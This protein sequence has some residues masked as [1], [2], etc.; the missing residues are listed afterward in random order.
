[1]FIHRKKS[2]VVQN[3]K[4]FLNFANFNQIFIQN[5]SKLVTPLKQFTW[6]N[7]QIECEN[8]SNIWDSKEY[9]YNYRYSKVYLFLETILSR[10]V[11]SWFCPWNHTF[12]IIPS[13][14]QFQVQYD[15]N[16]IPKINYE[17]TT[18]NFEPLSTPSKSGVIFLNYINVQSRYTL[19]TWFSWSMY[20]I[21][22]SQETWVHKFLVYF[23]CAN[24]QQNRLCMSL[25]QFNMSWIPP[26][27]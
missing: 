7:N 21:H 22:R 13:T 20:T 8:I 19:N 24:P 9:N 6:K 11:Y 26:L 5:Y 2:I 27:F 16:S 23:V 3:V 17:I 18:M 25:K 14:I 12:N 1:M 15:H 10:N 4:N